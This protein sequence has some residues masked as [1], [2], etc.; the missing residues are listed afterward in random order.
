[1]TDIAAEVRTILAYHLGIEEA[2]LT[3]EARLAEDLGA[4]SL[5]LVEIVMSFEEQFGIEIPNHA[6][7]GLTTVGDAVRF[8]EARRTNLQAQPAS[9]SD[10]WRLALR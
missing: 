3:D 9:Q 8:V 6:A 5:D 2:K 7:T 1:V 10:R 4:D